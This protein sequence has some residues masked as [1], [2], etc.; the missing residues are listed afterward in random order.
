MGL[1]RSTFRTASLPE[2]MGMRRPCR[3]ASLVDAIS[4][5]RPGRLRAVGRHA[6]R[7]CRL[8]SSGLVASRLVSC[9]LIASGIVS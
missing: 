4:L 6:F 8:I 3:P 2:A 1:C 9:G 7:A 5:I